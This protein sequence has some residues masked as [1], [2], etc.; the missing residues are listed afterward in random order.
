MR[1]KINV[2]HL[3]FSGSHA[4]GN[5]AL[6]GISICKSCKMSL[7][8][9]LSYC[10]YCV[11]SSHAYCEQII[12]N[13]IISALRSPDSFRP[14]CYLCKIRW[15]PICMRGNIHK[16]STLIKVLM[17]KHR[18]NDSWFLIMN[19]LLMQIV[20]TKVLILCW[21]KCVYKGVHVITCFGVCK[22]VSHIHTNPCAIWVYNNVTV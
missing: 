15:Y 8:L 19:N 6:M 1:V 18:I 13:E 3:W 14:R 20:L 12:Q 17:Y 2:A 9:E 22:S 21:P 10:L 7:V 4:S 16:V 11:V 5:I